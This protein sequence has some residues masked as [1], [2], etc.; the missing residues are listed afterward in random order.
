LHVLPKT[1]SLF[2]TLGRRNAIGAAVVFALVAVIKEKFE[3]EA[4]G[5]AL[6][7]KHFVLGVFGCV[8]WRQSL[9][10]FELV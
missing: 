4:F 8:N 3:L 1:V 10:N 6:D 7:A 9:S 5:V 2:F